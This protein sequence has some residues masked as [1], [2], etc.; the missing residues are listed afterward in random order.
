V[1]WSPAL[2]TSEPDWLREPRGRGVLETI[3]WYPLITFFQISADM[4]DS[5]NVPY[6]NGHVYQSH[7]AGA[8]AQIIPPQGWT[9]QDTV[10]LV[11]LVQ[12]NAG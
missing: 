4:M 3:D 7:Q 6:G 5:T 10:R 9:E 11:D 2:L 8:W 1:W 12:A